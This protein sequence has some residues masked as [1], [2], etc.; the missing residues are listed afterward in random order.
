VKRHIEAMTARARASTS[1]TT[2]VGDGGRRRR[3]GGGRARVVASSSARVVVEVFWDVDNLCPSDGCER[4][5]ARRL[6][7]AASAFGDVRR[8]R[9]FANEETMSRISLERAVG[10]ETTVVD[11]SGMGDDVD[12][13]LAAAAAAFARE[14]A[15]TTGAE[16]GAFRFSTRRR[17]RAMEMEA[18]A[19]EEAETEATREA[20]RWSARAR[21]ARSALP[22]AYARDETVEAIV[23]GRSRV[24]VIVTSDNDM[25]TVMD[26]LSSHGVAVVVIGNFANV[27]RAAGGMKTKTAKTR[28]KSMGTSG[29][30]KEYWEVVK[31]ECE[32]RELSRLKLLQS[33]DG[34]LL[35]DPNRTFDDVAGEIVGVW[36]PARGS[37]IGRWYG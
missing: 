11:A 5:V 4:E 27:P 15:E 17:R 8:C 16:T 3:G 19:S 21:D 20:A 23:R 37:G 22:S 32:K 14:G 9:A 35:F 25:T 33:C 36:F 10:V 2:R 18:V 28:V 24:A 6:T 1:T 29:M 13:A 30:T 26:Y 12:D 7:R 34:A 31:R